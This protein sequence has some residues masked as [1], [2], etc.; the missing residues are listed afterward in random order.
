MINARIDKSVFKDGIFVREDT[1]FFFLVDTSDPYFEDYITDALKDFDNGANENVLPCDTN[2]YNGSV[3]TARFTSEQSH[4]DYLKRHFLTTDG[5][6]SNIYFYGDRDDEWN[7]EWTLGHEQEYDR[8]LLAA[9]KIRGVVHVC[10]FMC[11]AEKFWPALCIEG[12]DAAMKERLM[13]QYA[14]YEKYDGWSSLVHEPR[15]FT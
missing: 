8:L 15:L 2:N 3:G 11:D 6:C 13:N 14:F 5:K 12:R 7:Y 10:Q 9:R 1:R 4:Y